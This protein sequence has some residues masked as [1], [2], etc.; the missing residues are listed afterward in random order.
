MAS[1]HWC[2]TEAW[3]SEVK[4]DFQYMEKCLDIDWNLKHGVHRTSVRTLSMLIDQYVLVG[5]DEEVIRCAASGRVFAE[6]IIRNGEKRGKVSGPFPDFDTSMACYY[7]MLRD[8]V[9]IVDGKEDSSITDAY[10]NYARKGLA[11]ITKNT[12][13]TSNR[14]RTHVFL[15]AALAGGLA[16]EA[17]EAYELYQERWPRSKREIKE[18]VYTL[19][20]TLA[21]LINAWDYSKKH[22]FAEDRAID[23][24]RD[25]ISYIRT[26]ESSRNF[27]E[28]LGLDEA[29]S[30]AYFVSKYVDELRVEPF[31][32][33]SVVRRIRY[34]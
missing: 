25:F 3:D 8:F 16:D 13:S 4:R 12:R 6:R 1:E 10:I 19:A 5:M 20:R 29:R 17:R 22:D 23:L 24:Y 27:S 18:D 28:E 15:H 30:V 2:F 26:G 7:C 31:T 21:E 9:W 11:L 32:F 33:Q 14:A 34:D